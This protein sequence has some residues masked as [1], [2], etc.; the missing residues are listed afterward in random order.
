MNFLK[1]NL[2]VASV[3]LLII[4][5]CVLKLP[6][7]HQFYNSKKVGIILNIKPIGMF[8]TG[9][10]GLLDIALTPGYKYEEPLKNVE[11][12]LE[13]KKK[14]QN[15]ISRILSSKEKKYEFIKENFDT[16]NNFDKPN[17]K[18]KYSKLDYRSL[19]EKYNVDEILVVN[20]VHGILVTYYGFIEIGREGFAQVSTEI[21]DLQDNSL[22][23]KAKFETSVN[24]EG[25]W[26]KG[27]DY[28]NLKNAIDQAIKAALLE[29]KY[30]FLYATICKQHLNPNWV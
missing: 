29:L 12:K 26:K 6:M 23:Q 15:E 4:S 13:Y 16:F 21:I 11:P 1:I 20:A 25:H 18:K 10:Q 22:L 9:S 24:I 30:K 2:L 28:E 19:K 3:L 27:E 8:K 5:S 7:N 14:L 17:N